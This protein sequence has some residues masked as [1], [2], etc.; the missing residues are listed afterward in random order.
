MT[1]VVDKPLLDE[2]RTAMRGSVIGPGD[3]GYGPP[4]ESSTA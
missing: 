3:A 1:L 4:A 2:L